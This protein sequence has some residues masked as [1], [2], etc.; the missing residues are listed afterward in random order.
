MTHFQNTNESFL[1]NCYCHSR[2]FSF[3]SVSRF[4]KS[5]TTSYHCYSY[6]SR[7]IHI[8]PTR[9]SSS[10]ALKGY[11]SVLFCSPDYP[12]TI[13]LTIETV[14]NHLSLRKC[15][16]HPHLARSVPYLALDRRHWHPSDV[17]EQRYRGSK[18]GHEPCEG[19]T[20]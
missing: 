11:A 15:R 2:K 3:K 1:S 16:P 14:L 4:L 12:R 6:P 8:D 5:P 18:V 20:S 10:I 19:I 13:P 7:A 17:L 9:L